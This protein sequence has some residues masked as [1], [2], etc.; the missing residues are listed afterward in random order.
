MKRIFKTALLIVTATAV[1]VPGLASVSL[2]DTLK[3]TNYSFTETALGGNS[4]LNAQSANFQAAASSALLGLGNTASTNLQVNAG[5][6][7]TS[8][9]ALTFIVNSP[10]VDFGSFDPT[11]AVT[12]TSTFEVTNYTSYGYVVQI[13]GSPPSNGGHTLA[14]MGTDALGG[15]EVSQVGREQFGINLV[16]NV[17]PASIGANPACAPDSSFCPFATL[18]SVVTANYSQANRYR[19]VSG[20]TIAS[21]PKSSGKITYTLSYV[22]NVSA[23]SPGGQY[24]G[25]QT[26]ICTGTY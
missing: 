2:A 17:S 16:A 10:T 12:S 18:T 13:F 21:A 4:L 1:A 24:T 15:P 5:H 9:P 23:V 19:F 11:N 26:L 8:D 20:D 7:T 14:A 25:N 22:A 6:L 3:S